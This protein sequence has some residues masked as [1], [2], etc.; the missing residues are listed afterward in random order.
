MK[1][2]VILV[3]AGA[4]KRLKASKPKALI[5]LK[6]RPLVWYALNAFEHAKQIKSVILVVHKSLVNQFRELVDK[7]RFKKVHV[8]TPGGKTRSESVQCGLRCLD[9]DAD[10]VMVHDAARPFVTERMIRSCLHAIHG[11]PAAIVAVPAKATIKKV[12]R[13]NLYV[14]E[15]LARDTLWEIQTP[16]T[17]KKDVLVKAHAAKNSV[18]P[19]DDAMLVED[20]GLPVKIVRGD[21]RNIKITTKEDLKLAELFLNGG[22]A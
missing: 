4:G 5:P 14:Q 3:A 17:F 2:Q 22:G 11:V 21:Y 16:Q 1:V 9:T 13:K 10:I 18:E 6:G 8:I 19:T 20:L 7:N 12:D 15:T